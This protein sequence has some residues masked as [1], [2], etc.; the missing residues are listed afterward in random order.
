M[1]SPQIPASRNPRAL[2]GGPSSPQIRDLHPCPGQDGEKL[3]KTPG[4]RPKTGKSPQKC[5]GQNS[6]RDLGGNWDNKVTTG[7]TEIWGCHQNIPDPPCP[8][9]SRRE[10]DPGRIRGEGKSPRKIGGKAGSACFFPH[11]DGDPVFQPPPGSTLA[12]KLPARAGTRRERGQGKLE[13]SCKRLEKVGKIHPEPPPGAG[14]DLGGGSHLRR[15]VGF[16][17]G[18][19]DKSRWKRPGSPRGAGRG[20]KFP[21][22][23]F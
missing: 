18:R 13:K 17:M 9:N 20:G 16:G 10:R 5:H 19:A 4:M 21:I 15:G 23:G 14:W 11:G 6:P 8:G 12:G 3:L 7:A 2:L 22:K 1:F